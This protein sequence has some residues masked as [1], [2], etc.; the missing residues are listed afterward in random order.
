MRNELPENA[1]RV[2]KGVI[3][4]VWQW[5]QKMYDDSIATFERLKRPDT[6]QVIAT[7][8]DKIILQAQSQPDQ[9]VPFPSLPGGCCDEGEEPLSAAKRELLEETG[10]VSRDWMLWKELN[11][12]S[13]IVWTVYIFVARGCSYDR[14][15]QLD[16]GERIDLKLVSFNEFIMLSEDPSFYEKEL[17]GTLWRARL[18]PK[19]RQELY[20]L[21]FPG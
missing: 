5:E 21:L 15:P 10:Y 17:V 18:D 7:V 6:A 12:V 14:A 9:P 3:F 2:F 4:E 1:K 8:G 11:P 13:K 16:A 20:K 19:F